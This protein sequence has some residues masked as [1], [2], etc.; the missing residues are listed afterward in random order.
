MMAVTGIEPA[1]EESTEKPAAEAKEARKPST[2][3]G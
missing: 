2:L 3:L 1:K